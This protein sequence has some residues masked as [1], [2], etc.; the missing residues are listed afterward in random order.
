[1]LIAAAANTVEIQTSV[2]N[3]WWLLVFLRMKAIKGTVAME[4]IVKIMVGV[5]TSKT[6]IIS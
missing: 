6:L 4:Q 3:P 5:S 2:K 1:M